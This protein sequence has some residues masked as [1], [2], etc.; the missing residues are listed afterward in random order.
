MSFVYKCNTCDTMR[1][2]FAWHILISFVL[3]IIMYSYIKTKFV[4]T[5]KNY[6]EFANV[7]LPEVES[8][9]VWLTSLIWTNKLLK[10]SW[11]VHYT[12][13]F[14]EHAFTSIVLI[15]FVNEATSRHVAVIVQASYYKYALN[16]R[17][18]IWVFHSIHLLLLLNLVLYEHS[19]FR[20]NIV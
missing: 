18:F 14:V 10:R 5:W 4:H 3:L 2:E 9:W 12:M 6:S 13:W 11:F 16:F 17:F 1:D 20:G 15:A 7:I 8:T 19:F